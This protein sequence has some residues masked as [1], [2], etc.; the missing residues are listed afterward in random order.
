MADALTEHDRAALDEAV[1]QA[2][3][4]LAEGGI[5]IGAAL[6]TPAGEIVAADHNRRVQSGDTTAHGEISC[7]RDAGRRR[8]W[9]ELTMATTLSPCP[10]CS[11]AA[12]LHRLRRVVIGE[13]TTFQGREDW[14]REAGIQIAVA[15]DPRCEKLMRSFI[16]ANPELWNED[17]AI[18][19]TA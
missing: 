5:P 17:I 19:P 2:E 12:V 13:N 1:R 6:I 7:L 9:H 14:L 16:A 3:K 15:D 11:G 10:M 18:P 8:D 4:S